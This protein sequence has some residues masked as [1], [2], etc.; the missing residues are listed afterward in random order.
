[1]ESVVTLSE[2]DAGEIFTLQRAAYVTEAHAPED[3]YLP[4][5]VESLI[6]VTSELDKAEVDSFGLRDGA[7]RL[8]GAVRV[9]VLPANARC[10]EVGRLVVAPDVQVRGLGSRLLELVEARVSEDITE[11]KL[12]TGEHSVGNL[13]LYSRFGY[14]ETHRVPTASGYGLVY[15]S[16]RV[17]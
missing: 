11:L 16:K 8:L 9:C 13:R 5:L 3:L 15:L 14:R 1:M 2:K 17:R 10:T 6:E 4:P 12:F 7:Q